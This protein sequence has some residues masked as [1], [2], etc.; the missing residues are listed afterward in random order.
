MV[1]GSAGLVVATRRDQT[2][3]RSLRPRQ[4]VPARPADDPCD[5]CNG[6]KNSDGKDSI[7]AMT[8]H[9]T[10]GGGKQE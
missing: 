7:E 3:F 6:K 4:H 10:R 1:G 9:S 8:E 5:Q 2:V